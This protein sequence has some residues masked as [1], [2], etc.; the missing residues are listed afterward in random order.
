MTQT[1]IKNRH[2]FQFVDIIDKALYDRYIKTDATLER[3]VVHENG[4]IDLSETMINVCLYVDYLSFEEWVNSIDFD[5][6]CE[7]L[8]KMTDEVDESILEDNWEKALK[9]QLLL[10]EPD[11][12][13]GC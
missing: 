10:A 3:F 13:S 6:A 7:E 8:H 9:I 12:P 4:K 5:F 11:N 1:Q 2:V